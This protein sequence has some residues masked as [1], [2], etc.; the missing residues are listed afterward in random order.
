MTRVKAEL[1]ARAL[2]LGAEE[3]SLDVEAPDPQ[4]PVAW[5][6][7]AALCLASCAH[8]YSVCSIFSYAGIMSTEL[9]W[10]AD[11][12]SAGTFAGFLQSANVLGRMP[13]ATF[14]GWYSDRF[15]AKSGLCWSMALI[16]LG[17]VLFGLVSDR[18]LAVIIRFVV[19]GMGNGWVTIFCPFAMDLAGAQQ[20]VKLT[21]VVFSAGTL[22]QLFGPAVG[23]WTYGFWPAFPA[24]VPSLLGA[25]IAAVAGLAIW[26]WLPDVRCRPPDQ[27]AAGSGRAADAA[28]T[29]LR[30]VF[31]WPL[32]A[33]LAKRCL[34]GYSNFAFFE[35][36]PLWAISSREMG[37]LALSESELGNLLALSALGS[38]AFMFV[39][40]P[41]L[42]ECTGLRGS[43]VLGNALAASFYVALPLSP[44]AA[45]LTALHTATNCWM[46]W[47]NVSYVASINN[48]VPSGYKARVNGFC[49]TLEAMAKGF[50]PASTAMAFAWT[51][52]RWGN[53]G[54]IAVF[55]GLGALHLLMCAGTWFLSGAVESAPKGLGRFDKAKISPVATAHHSVP[56]EVVGGFSKAHRRRD[57]EA[58]KADAST[59]SPEEE[60]DE[61]ENAPEPRERAVPSRPA[62]GMAGYR[63]AAAADGASTASTRALPPGGAA[64]ALAA[65]APGAGPPRRRGRS[66]KSGKAKYSRAATA[67]GANDVFGPEA[68]DAADES[69]EADAADS[70]GD[71]DGFSCREEALEQNEVKD[72]A[73]RAD[74]E[75][76]LAAGGRPAAA[77]RASPAPLR[78]GGPPPCRLGV[79]DCEDA[80]PPRN[81]EWLAA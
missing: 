64:E 23:G 41:R 54:H 49:A 67:D 57:V 3:L 33:L 77:P 74:V 78:P 15:G 62:K 36:V 10:A 45:V 17:N 63:P 61:E 42:A 19:L 13:T 30:D 58:A 5:R 7:V 76:G 80:A 21:S 75:A 65:G 56:A 44:N 12:D 81:Q 79:G 71:A 25:V 48:I 31:A 29:P 47:L 55:V 70:T 60:E 39:V 24:L 69:D 72:G 32:P 38:G 8:F 14:W 9:G 1:P 43:M 53:A 40:L 20:Q 11:R 26:R 37:G 46:A 6:P 4:E 52:S 51:L 59:D 2:K 66:A 50:G 27:G 28:A 35:V 16:G 68:A 34:A 73:G 18:N 22:A